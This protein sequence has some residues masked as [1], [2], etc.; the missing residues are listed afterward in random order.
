M[1]KKLLVILLLF[2][3]MASAYEL[4]GE[5]LIE[6]RYYEGNTLIYNDGD[7]AYSIYSNGMYL[8][9]IESDQ[10]MYVNETLDYSLY[11]SYSHIRDLT[12]VD[13]M[14]HKFNQWWLIIVIALV[15][16]MV[17]VKVYKV[18]IR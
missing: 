1:I 16:L 18:I 8:G 7:I 6:P 13:T 11:A 17:G 3:S 5:N 4:T 2:T 10:G 15:I 14:K 9:T 12:D